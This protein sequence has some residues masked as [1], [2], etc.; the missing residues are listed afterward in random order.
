MT[1]IQERAMVYQFGIRQR[2]MHWTDQ[3][4]KLVQELLGAMRVV[5]WFTYEG[6]FLTRAC[7][8]LLALYFVADGLVFI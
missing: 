2:S 5:K 4:A 7:R 1:P 3:R 8:T 6:A